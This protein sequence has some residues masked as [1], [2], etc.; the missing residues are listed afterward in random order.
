MLTE[1]VDD[2][3]DSM[4]VSLLK[5][6]FMDIFPGQEDMFEVS[7]DLFNG[8]DEEE[9]DG[10]DV[11]FTQPPPPPG[12]YPPPPPLGGPRVPRD[13][14][15]LMKQLYGE[16]EGP[17]PDVEHILTPIMNFEFSVA[18][19]EAHEAAMGRPL[20]SLGEMPTRKSMPNRNQ[21][22]RHGGG[23]GGK[24]KSQ[25][26]PPVGVD[27]HPATEDEDGLAK[28]DAGGDVYRRRMRKRT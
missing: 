21:N 4:H 18:G 11:G 23:R 6:K 22:R 27:S 19:I 25:R 10:Q 20:P 16:A 13:L 26:D 9:F 14:H 17:V 28:F 1:V 15:Q 3:L 5:Y 12:A 2:P 24:R 7:P 8:Y